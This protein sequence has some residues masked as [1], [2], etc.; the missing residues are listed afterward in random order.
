MDLIY[1]DKNKMDIGVLKDYRLDLAYGSDENDFEL[2]V[3]M[4][5]NV[6]EEDFYIYIEGTEYG[7]IIDSIEVNTK[8]KKI[9]YKGRTFHGILDKK[10]VCPDSGSNYYEITDELNEGIRKVI[11][12]SGL[13]DLF[14][15][16]TD[17]CPSTVWLFRYDHAYT[18]LRAMCESSNYKLK[19]NYQNGK[20]LIGAI[21]SE[22]YDDD[23]GLDSDR[24]SF[25]IQQ[26][27][28]SVNHLVCLGTGQMSERTVVHL[29]VDQNGNIG[30]TQYYRNA[31]EITEVFDYPNAESVSELTKQGKKKLQEYNTNSIEMSLGEGYEFDV[32]DIITVTDVVTGVTVTRKISKKI[33]TI[34]S[35]VLK[36]NYEVGE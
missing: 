27:F 9:K 13:G 35:S 2:T 30:T 5:N 4:S 15:A 10:I 3:P 19:L 18:E 8:D 29:Y 24:I 11:N 17:S 26:T 6:C 14:Q 7:G 20:V 36:V 16:S 25:D 33:V 31:E 32:G 22:V 34:D 1:A 12:R 21:P 23:S 28:N